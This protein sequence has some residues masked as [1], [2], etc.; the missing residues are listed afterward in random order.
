MSPFQVYVM[1]A[2]DRYMCPCNYYPNQHTEQFSHPKKLSSAP[3]HVSLQSSSS[4][5]D[6]HLSAFM[7]S[8]YAEM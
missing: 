8:F 7:K 4:V 6:N 1:M 2:F 3:L 5:P